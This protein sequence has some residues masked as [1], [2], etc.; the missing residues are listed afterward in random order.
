MQIEEVAPAKRIEGFAR[1]FDAADW[2]NPEL[3][4]YLTLTR[5][6][7]AAPPEKEKPPWIN[8]YD[9]PFELYRKVPQERPPTPLPIK[10]S[11]QVV[12]AVLATDPRL[13]ESMVRDVLRAFREHPQYMKMGH[14]R[15]YPEALACF[16]LRCAVVQWP[17]K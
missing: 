7:D 4:L 2:R 11:H 5:A 14:V 6:T 15:Q 12:K 8:P 1:P 17:D 9:D 10:L 3:N 13:I 16:Q